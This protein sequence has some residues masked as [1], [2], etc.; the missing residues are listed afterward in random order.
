MTKTQVARTR[1]IKLLVTFVAFL[2]AL[3]F[4][5]PI[6]WMVGNAVRPQ[7]NIFKYL[8]PLSVR[9]FIPFELTIENFV[10]LFAGFFLRNI[11]N[12]LVVAVGTI[13]IG[14]LL[15]ATAAYALSALRFRYRELVFAAVV[16]SFMIPFEAVAIPLLDL[17]QRWGLRNSYI[18]LILPGVANGLAIFLLRQ[19]F[20]GIPRDLLD[21]SRVD[22][23]GHWT[24]FSIVYAPLSKPAMIGAG[25]ML[26]IWQWQAYIWPLLIVSEPELDV[27]SVALAK[28]MGQFEY[29]F[30]VMFAGAFVLS[31]I[32]ALIL[33]PL[34][35]YITQS[36][37]HTGLK[38]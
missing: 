33:L 12:S 17:F 37:S 22:G 36:V 11:Y 16:V 4:L 38:E 21:A 31:L 18:G 29:N 23:A 28:Y 14:V 26:F 10:T 30:S 20:L 9:A 15:S 19:F 35:K 6:I 34:Q 1:T 3:A 32:P 8:S 27:A 24:I 7:E 25:L 5:L 2:V 13:A